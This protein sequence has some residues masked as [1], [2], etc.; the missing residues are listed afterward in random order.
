MSESL[1]RQAL[2]PDWDRLPQAIRQLHEVHTHHVYAGEANVENGVTL[3]SRICRVLMRFPPAADVLPIEVILQRDGARERWSRRFGAHPFH[4]ILSLPTDGE[5][6][7]VIER[8]GMLSFRIA[9]PVT[10]HGLEMPVK[11]AY[12][13]GIPLPDWLMPRSQTREFVDV[14]GRFNFDVAVYLPL[15]GL[16]VRYRGW[17]QPKSEL[18]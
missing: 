9:L 6:G 17:L 8:F 5:R 1:Y 4:S 16:I 10:A 7:I 15:A 2:G 3:L 14:Q 13:L 18:R 11:R 12:C